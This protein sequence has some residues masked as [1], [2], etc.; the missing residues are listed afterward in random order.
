MRAHVLVRRT[1]PL[2]TSPAICHRALL[3]STR[4]HRFP[5]KKSPSSPAPT[6]ITKRAAS[7]VT[8]AAP[9]DPEEPEE[10]NEEGLEEEYVPSLRPLSEEVQVKRR[11]KGQ[12]KT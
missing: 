2:I 4:P 10:T 1:R 5:R 8:A 7:S 9:P 11:P 6:C 3:S 12:K